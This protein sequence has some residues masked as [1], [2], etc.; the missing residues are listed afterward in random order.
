MLLIYKFYSVRF[1]SD[2]SCDMTFYFQINLQF[3]RLH[4]NSLMI[5]M[6]SVQLRQY[7]MDAGGE[8]QAEFCHWVVISQTPQ[9]HI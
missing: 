3:T 1:Y 6:M 4:Y 8:T 2:V 9:R 5:A 7:W